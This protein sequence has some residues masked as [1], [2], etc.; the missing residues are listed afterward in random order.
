MLKTV[1]NTIM[2][3]DTYLIDEEVFC[4]WLI[5]CTSVAGFI[6]GLLIQRNAV[7]ASAETEFA[8]CEVKAPPKPFTG[9]STYSRSVGMAEFTCSE[10]CNK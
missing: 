7:K 1:E 10:H 2:E 6:F 4:I 8:T 9:R 5:T 3:C